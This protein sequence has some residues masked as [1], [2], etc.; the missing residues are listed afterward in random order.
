MKK[1]LIDSPRRKYRRLRWISVDSSEKFSFQ[2]SI[3]GSQTLEKSLQQNHDSQL[4]DI[5]NYAEN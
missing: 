1:T 4:L 3:S 2:T 5:K